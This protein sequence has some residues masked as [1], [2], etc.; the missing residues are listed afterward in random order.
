MILGSGGEG[1]HQNVRLCQRGS[2]GQVEQGVIIQGSPK[3]GTL[4]ISGSGVQ[5]VLIQ[6]SPNVGLCRDGLGVN[7]N[8]FTTG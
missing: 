2:G 3:Y 5:G 6:G 4:G 8:I 7:C 1:G